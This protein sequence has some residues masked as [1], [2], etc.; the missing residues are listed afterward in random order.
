MWVSGVNT[1]TKAGYSIGTP[2]IYSCLN[3]SN[4]G[5]VE[6]PHGIKTTDINVNNIKILNT[7][8]TVYIKNS[9]SVSNAELYDDEKRF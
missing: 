3:I 7:N 8:G 1:W 2:V 4:S 9:L 5:N 6:M